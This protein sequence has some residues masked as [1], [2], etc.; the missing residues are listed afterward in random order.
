M[1][2]FRSDKEEYIDLTDDYVDSGGGSS[3]TIDAISDFALTEKNTPIT[4]DVLANDIDASNL[5]SITEPPNNGTAEI[6]DN[7]II[8]TPNTD[9][10][11]V[12]KLRYKIIDDNRNSSEEYLYLYVVSKPIPETK[13]DFAL[14][15]KNT[16]I[17]IDV[18]TNDEQGLTL[19]SIVTTPENGTAEIQDN[20][21]VYTPNTDYVGVD[22]FTYKVTKNG[23][24]SNNI[25]YVYIEETDNLCETY[26]FTISLNN[27]NQPI[28][29]V[30]DGNI[31]QYIKNNSDTNIIIKNGKGE[32]ITLL[33]N[34]SYKLKCTDKPYISGVT[35]PPLLLNVNSLS[36]GVTVE[37]DSIIQTTNKTGGDI[38]VIE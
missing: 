6:Q 3:S 18:L 15:D 23:E 36:S 25:V 9:Y 30:K 38:Y 29:I 33:P 4:I 22:S 34:E 37:D 13:A 32:L 16:P 1:F 35:P 19:D 26:K 11:G 14:T 10:T 27:E 7:K 21:I 28:N 20:K 17:T 31:E 24:E 2:Y 8:Y 5:D 12:D